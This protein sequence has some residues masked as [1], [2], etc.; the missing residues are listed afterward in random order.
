[1]ST[2]D[3]IA[4]A[5]KSVDTTDRIDVLLDFADRLPPLPDHLIPLR[6]DERH[7]VHECQAPVFLF[8]TVD[9]GIVHI[10]GDVPREAPTARSFL[11]I[12]IDAFDG[13]PVEVLEQ[14]PSDALQALGL[15]SMLGM[16]RTRGLSGIYHQLRARVEALATATK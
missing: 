9:D 16:Q 11:S 4:D 6:D 10:F 8:V 3:Q 12:L 13:K 2:F 15:S 5:L 7:L 14:A 1:M